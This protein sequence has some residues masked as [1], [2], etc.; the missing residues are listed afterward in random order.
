VCIELDV[1]LVSIN[2]NFSTEEESRPWP[3]CEWSKYDDPIW[4]LVFRNDYP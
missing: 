1:L 4:P 3:I 2:Y